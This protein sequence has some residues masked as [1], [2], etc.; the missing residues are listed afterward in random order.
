MKRVGQAV[1]ALSLAL[2]LGAC[3]K[4]PIQKAVAGSLLP[5]EE[6]VVVTNHCQGCHLH[7][8]FNAEAHLA[9]IR[10]LYPADSPLRENTQCLKCHQLKL[11][12]IFRNEVRRTE[13]P[14]KNLVGLTDIP[15]PAAVVKAPDKKEMPKTEAEQNKRKWYFFYLF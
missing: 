6:N 10:D 12:N 13:F 7:A 3:A 4:E 2:A 1:A 15:K 5:A 11:E 8:K 14:H 9:K